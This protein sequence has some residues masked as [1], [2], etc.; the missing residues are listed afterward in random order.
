MWNLKYDT[1]ELIKQK[2]TDRHEKTNL[3]LPKGRWGE[4]KVRSLGLADT[5][6]YI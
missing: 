4:G 3:W 5:D 1:N 2:Q 6:D